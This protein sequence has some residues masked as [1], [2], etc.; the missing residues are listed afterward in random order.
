MFTETLFGMLFN[1]SKGRD[2]ALITLVL[3]LYKSFCIFDVNR[4]KLP[5]RTCNYGPH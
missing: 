2:I 3:P 1:S 4:R 5:I